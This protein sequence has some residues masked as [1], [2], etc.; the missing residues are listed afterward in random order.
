MLGGPG[1]GFG[2]RCGHGRRSPFRQ[3]DAIDPGA[4]GSPEQG[5][6]VVGIFDTVESKEEFVLAWVGWRQQVLYPEE[7]ALSNES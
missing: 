2:H 4:I 1:R 3:N 7:F 6:K 5:S